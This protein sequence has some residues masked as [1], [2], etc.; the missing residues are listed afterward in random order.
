MNRL[1]T[2]GGA[3]QARQSVTALALASSSRR[4]L[5][6]PAPD[7]I[8]PIRVMEGLL[9]SLYPPQKRRA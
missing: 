2:I 9:M 7:P 6:L 1:R 8:Q 3:F 4:A 5:L